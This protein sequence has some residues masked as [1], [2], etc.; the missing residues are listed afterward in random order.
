MI[1]FRGHGSSPNKNAATHDNSPKAAS[2]GGLFFITLAAGSGG[3]SWLRCGNDVKLAALAEENSNEQYTQDSS[4]YSGVDW[5]GA[6][7]EFNAACRKTRTAKRDRGRH[8]RFGRRGA[9]FGTS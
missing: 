8:R 7:T 3:R 4:D 9:L 6:Y 1:G 2:M 5:R